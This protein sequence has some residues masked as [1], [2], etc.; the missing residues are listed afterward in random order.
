MWHAHLALGFTGGTPVPRYHSRFGLLIEY[1]RRRHPNRFR[2][3]ETMASE[4]LVNFKEFWPRLREDILS[5]RDSIYIQT[6]AL[7]GDTVGLQLS[8]ALLS[9]RIADKRILADSFTRIVLSDRFRYS[10]ANLFDRSLRDEAR[11][12]AAMTRALRNRGVKIRYTNGYGATPRRLLSRNHKKL[13]VI[14]DR[15]A[16]V[17]GI[18]FSEHNASWHDMMIRMDDAPAVAFLTKDFRSTWDGGDQMASRSFEGVELLTLD[19]RANRTAF[20]RVI[21]LIDGAERSI[22]V[23][24]PYITF[25]FYERLREASRRGVDV[26]VVTPEANNWSYFSNY[27]R[28]ESARSNIDLRLYQRGMTHLK[29]MLIDDQYLIAGSSNFDYLSYRL[30]QEIVAIITDAGT[31]ADFRER[32]MLPDLANSLA[33]DCQASALRKRWL[34]LQ[35]KVFD[36]ALTILT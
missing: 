8:E 20:Q 26:K 16:Y 6:F 21:D 33:V 36:A 7:E 12:T 14:D 5:A 24:S 30:Y 1:N 32:V 11:S 34:G 9:S 31:I 3:C 15:T 4:L 25:P 19:G 35:T 2:N 29:A 10:P 13:I 28:L 27:A 22:F 23:E 17:G 18:N